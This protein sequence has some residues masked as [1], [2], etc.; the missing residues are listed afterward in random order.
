MTIEFEWKGKSWE[1]DYDGVTFIPRHKYQSENKEGQMTDRS[2]EL[3]FFSQ[4][5]PAIKKIV[6]QEFG[7]SQESIPLA[8]FV[9]R[10]EAA[11]KEL[12]QMLESE[13]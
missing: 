1:I 2:T 8:V 9:E 10:Y 3:G 13:F 11:V 5:G 6:G 12:K 4:L 7:R